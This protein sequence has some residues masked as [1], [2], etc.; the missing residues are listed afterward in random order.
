[1]AALQVPKSEAFLGA[2]LVVFKEI[3]KQSG[4]AIS[5]R[6]LI[7]AAVRRRAD[8]RC[9]ASGAMDIGVA[10]LSLFANK[11]PAVGILEQRFLCNCEAL[12]RATSRQH[13]AMAGI[14]ARAPRTL[15]GDGHNH[16]RRTCAST[17][18]SLMRRCD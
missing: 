4:N 6:C 1:R 12:V 15:E 3:E 17:S 14:A 7:A 11:L 16:A 10:G 18:S 5:V 8:P 9:V 2:S 13:L